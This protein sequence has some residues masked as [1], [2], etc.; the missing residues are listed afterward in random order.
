[1]LRYIIPTTSLL[2][3]IGL[4][5]GEESMSNLMLI[6]RLRGSAGSPWFIE[7]TLRNLR[8]SRVFN[9]MLYPDTNP[10]KG[11]LIKV[12][13]Y[14][15]WG[16]PSDEVLSML[17]SKLKPKGK[18]IEEALKSIGVEN[19]SNLKQAIVEG[20]IKLHELDDTFSLP[21]RLHPPRGGFK[22]SVKRPFK[23]E[24][25][26]GYRGQKINELVKRMI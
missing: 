25:E 5:G 9:A 21:L 7:E 12:Q 11:M 14:V 10:L 2:Q 18:T 17:L 22:G 6:I 1:M 13:P 8:L 23:D 15:T 24:G 26:F 20:K 3:Q 4:G 16:E 19:T